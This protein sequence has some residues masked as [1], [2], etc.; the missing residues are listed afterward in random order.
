MRVIRRHE[1]GELPLAGLGDRIARTY[2]FRIVIKTHRVVAER[3]LEAMCHARIRPCKAKSGKFNPVP[4]VCC[5][6][7]CDPR[8]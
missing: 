4:T 2:C 8:L 5:G 7:R 6:R 1:S 3:I